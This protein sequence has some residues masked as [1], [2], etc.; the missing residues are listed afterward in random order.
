MIRPVRPDDA[1]AIRDIYN[2][3]IDHT[4]VTFEEVQVTAEEMVSR[5]ARTT[6]TYPWLVYEEDGKVLGY[7]YAG[8]WKERSAYRYAVEIAIYLDAGSLG[9]GIG[10]QLL[11]MLLELLKAQKYHSAIYGVSLPN[12]ASVALCEKFGF[13]K[14]AHFDEVGYK[15][16]K[17]ID[18]G[19]WE[20]ILE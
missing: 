17:W 6:K 19:Y 10:T 9:N 3:Y 1:G 18:V 11:G 7:A 4:W 14:I 12:A 2:A 13:K 20:L 16:E 8:R 15:L 5:I